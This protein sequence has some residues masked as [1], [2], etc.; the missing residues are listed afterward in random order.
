MPKRHRRVRI[1]SFAYL[2]I[3]QFTGA[4]NDNLFKLVIVFLL[5][6]VHGQAVINAVMIIT[7]AIFIAPYLLFSVPAGTLSDRRSKRNIIVLVKTIEIFVMLL[8]VVAFWLQSGVL[9]YVVLFSMS[10]LAAVF[11]PAK[12]GIVPEIVEREKIA[13]ANGILTG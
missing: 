10:T 8:G 12:Y 13:T 6:H 3:C 9:S 2:N 5:V 4:L 1:S 11:S 7:G